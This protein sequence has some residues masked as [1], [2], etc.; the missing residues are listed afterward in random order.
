ME[1]RL[2]KTS[3][4]WGLFAATLLITVAFALLRDY[5][6]ISFIDGIA[7]P[8]L[9]REA[10]SSFTAEQRTQHAWITATLDVA[11]PLAYG[12][13][14]AG[15]AMC[16]FP[17]QARWLALPGLLAIPIDLLEGV[18]QV[19]ALVEI[20][21]WLALKAVLTPLKMYLFLAGLAITVAGWGRWLWQR[22]RG[23][24]TDAV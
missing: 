22:I 16:F 21:D 11:Y 23:R 13:F 17:R 20:V 6:G 4:L 24:A 10:I 1:Q 18:I 14:F 5:L 7:S 8:E 9:T 2:T 12:L 19:L 3:T 15:S